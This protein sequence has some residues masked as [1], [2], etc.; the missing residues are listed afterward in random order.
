MSTSLHLSIQEFDRMVDC[1]AFEVS[2]R[3]VKSDLA[4]KAELY[5]EAGI[6]EY[7][8]VDAA[9][10]CIHVYREPR[11]T[12]YMNCSIARPGE[13]LS[14]LAGSDA[15]FDVCDLFATE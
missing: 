3:S 1:G 2:Y 6:R 8:I 12:E 9:A 14:P 10:T 11:G 13:I 15:K 7:W 5:A 4:E